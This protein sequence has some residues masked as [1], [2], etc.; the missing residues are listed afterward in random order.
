M[1][2]CSYRNDYVV[3]G[4]TRRYK[5]EKLSHTELGYCRFHDDDYLTKQTENEITKLFMDE[6]N[7]AV[8]TNRSLLCIGYILPSLKLSS[9]EIPIEIRFDHSKFKF[10]KIQLEHLSFMEN[11]SFSS[12]MFYEDVTFDHVHFK[13]LTYFEHSILKKKLSM[14]Y[15]RASDINF[16]RTIFNDADFQKSQ[17]ND[18]DFHACK[19]N[20][21]NFQNNTSE[22]T[23][24]T[25]VKFFNG[26][27]FCDSIFLKKTDFE[28]AFFLKLTKFHKIQFNEK[29]TYFNGNI[30]NISF[31]NT[32]VKSIHFGNYISWNFDDDSVNNIMKKSYN[33]KICEERQLENNSH[34]YDNLE[35]I[36][37]I[38]RDLRDNFDHNLQYEKSGKFFIREM[39][40]HRNYEDH[41][42]NNKTFIRKKKLLYRY[43]SLSFVYYALA[44]YGQS[45]IIP[46]IIIC[47]I[48][49]IGILL[50]SSTCLIELDSILNVMSCN[51]D[52]KNAITRTIS[53]IPPFYLPKDSL[54]L[55]DY[56][57]RIVLLPLFGLLFISLKRR[58]ER[59][60]RH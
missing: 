8:K 6:F 59:K 57:M 48:I 39:E 36:Q 50:L 2:I 30:S 47:T 58:F 32:D 26:G 46:S 31:M 4:K 35:S 7:D 20:S 5:C 29:Y 49:F 60:L 27:T 41:V 12:C 22:T 25:Y 45:Y 34:S 28:Q 13:K 42:K 18:I 1:N 21:I 44:K 16:S 11:V 23:K 54:G 9:I 14:L 19:F 33:Y 52:I 51:N 53:I 55:Y 37:N 3:D 43:I 17:F 24:F 56:G 40:L 10:E 38:C 15:I